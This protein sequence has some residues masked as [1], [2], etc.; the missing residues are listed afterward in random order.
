MEELKEEVS[1]K[2][3]FRRKLVRREQ[4]REWM[5]TEWEVEGKKKTVIE[6]GGLCEGR[7]GRIWRACRTR[8][9]DG[10]M[11]MAVKWN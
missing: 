5:H 2:E 7:F 1:V 4:L 10:R 8:S 11:D 9:R 6:M 3:S